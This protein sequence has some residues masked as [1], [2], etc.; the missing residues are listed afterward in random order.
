MRVVSKSL[1]STMVVAL[2]LFFAACKASAPAAPATSKPAQSQPVVAAP[3][4]SAPAVDTNGVLSKL[5]AGM[6]YS[7]L[8]NTL[9]AD[10]WL[11]LRDTECWDNVGG[12]AT[13]CDLLP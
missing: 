1:R 9:L 12:K 5:S 6:A 3:I 2:A 11:P 8:R 7:D 13:V 4:A 10:G